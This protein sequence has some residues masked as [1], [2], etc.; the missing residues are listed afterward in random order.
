MNI[1][2]KAVAVAGAALLSEGL[3]RDG[4]VPALRVGANGLRSAANKMD[5][6]ADYMDV[7]NE[8]YVPRLLKDLVAAGLFSPNLNAPIPVQHRPVYG[9]P[10]PKHRP[11]GRRSEPPQRM[12]R[13]REDYCNQEADAFLEDVYNQARREDAEGG[14]GLFPQEEDYLPEGR[15]AQEI[16]LLPRE[17]T[18]EEEYRLGMQRRRRRQRRPHRSGS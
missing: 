12:R 17:L 9:E 14:G 8:E 18:P 5:A 16:N 4:A 2:Q 6:A 1:L 13:G 7:P 3:R 10:R 15:H 11:R